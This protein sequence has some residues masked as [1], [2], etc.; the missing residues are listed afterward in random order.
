MKR[1]TAF[2]LVCLLMFSIVGCGKK[3]TPADPMAEMHKSALVNTCNSM[4]DVSWFANGEEN[5]GSLWDGV[6]ES[7]KTVITNDD[8]ILYGE[9]KDESGVSHRAVYMP[10]D[11]Q[12]S[13]GIS[14]DDPYYFTICIS[15]R[16]DVSIEYDKNA[17]L[18]EYNK[19]KGYIELSID[20]SCFPK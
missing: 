6:P 15:E 10:K 16:L 20:S 11:S 18:D 17:M 1:I 7:W 2:V 12:E 4:K 13:L 19:D 8:S 5:S 9:Y 14:V 3:E